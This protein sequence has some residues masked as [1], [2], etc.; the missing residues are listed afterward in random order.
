[1]KMWRS[2]DKSRV[3]WFQNL[4][5]G[6][7]NRR[8]SCCQSH[9]RSCWRSR[10]RTRWGLPAPL[11]YPGCRWR[12]PRSPQC[13]WTASSFT[14]RKKPCLSMVGV[15][16]VRQLSPCAC[17][18]LPP[19]GRRRTSLFHGAPRKTHCGGVLRRLL[20]VTTEPH[21]LGGAVDSTEKD[22]QGRGRGASSLPN[23][24]LES[25]A[26]PVTETRLRW[27]RGR[28][29]PEKGIEGG[30]QGRAFITLREKL[31]LVTGIDR[32]W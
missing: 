18:R 23:L 7:E 32:L 2:K 15:A 30:R 14:L 12:S 20:F 28:R 24:R 16:G 29:R 9:R 8:R 3:W 19:L 17:V 1:M 21:P 31:A 6:V 11:F 10:C 25:R 26:I 13:A 27:R 22:G 4:P 5:R